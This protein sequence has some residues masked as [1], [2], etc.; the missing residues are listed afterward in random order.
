[1]V[2][3]GLFLAYGG[4]MVGMGAEHGG[5]FDKGHTLRTAARSRCPFASQRR[6]TTADYTPAG[7]PLLRAARRGAAILQHDLYTA[8]ALAVTFPP[9]ATAAAAA[10][11]GGKRGRFSAWA[12]QTSPLRKGPGSPRG[13]GSHALRYMYTTRRRFGG[14]SAAQKS[15]AVEGKL[16]GGTDARSIFKRVR[17]HPI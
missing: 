2:Y 4:R 13:H 14:P 7:H 8:S 12:A 10:D 9:P 11:T 3:A 16:N 6:P 17:Q 5:P 1:M 15:T